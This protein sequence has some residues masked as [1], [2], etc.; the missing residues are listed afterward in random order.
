[1]K[2]I[3]NSDFEL[4]QDVI[5]SIDFNYNPQECQNLE[6]IQDFWVETVGKKIINY[7]KVYNF[8]SD[9]TLT[10]VCSDSFVSNELYLEKDKLLKNMNKKAQKMGIKIED[11]KFDYKKWKEK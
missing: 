7:A 3:K 5:K 9:N 11:I 10:I 2:K 1:M 8:L 6:L 4:L